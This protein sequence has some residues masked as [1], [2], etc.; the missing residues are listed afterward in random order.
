LGIGVPWT[1]TA[2]TESMVRRRLVPRNMSRTAAPWV[3]W[4]SSSMANC[5]CASSDSIR[6]LSG[7]SQISDLRACS[8]F[9]RLT[10]Q[11]GDSGMKSMPM[12]WMVGTTK[13]RP[14]GIM[15]EARDMIL[16]VKLSTIVPT[17]VP[18]EVQTWKAASARPRYQAGA[19][20]CK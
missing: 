11:R 8:T 4:R 12:A 7:R 17:R 3:R 14:R 20:S 10:S 13:I 9:P 18:T 15:Y 19:T 6:S 1:E 16:E 2:P 5:I